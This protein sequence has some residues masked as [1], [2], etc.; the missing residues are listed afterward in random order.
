MDDL[1]DISLHPFAVLKLVRANMYDF[2]LSLLSGL[3]VRYCVLA[4]TL[5]DERCKE[6]K[7]FFFG[8]IDL[9]SMLE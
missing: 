8:L 5:F 1:A 9:V 3:S 7:I 4:K 6:A 2:S